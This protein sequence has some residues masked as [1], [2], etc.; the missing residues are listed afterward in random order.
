MKTMHAAIAAT[1]LA[2]TTFTA[3]AATIREN[4]LVLKI[5]G[6]TVTKAGF[7]PDE[8]SFDV[9]SGQPKGK[10][11]VVSSFTDSNRQLN[12]RVFAGRKGSGGVAT[13]FTNRTVKRVATRRGDASGKPGKLNFTFE[14][15]L[16]LNG[17]SFENFSFGQGHKGTNNN[18]WA[19]TASAATTSANDGSAFICFEGQSGTTYQI[20]MPGN[21]SAELEVSAITGAQSCGS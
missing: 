19:G 11:A 13:T 20:R 17:D 16:V 1:L 3:D 4:D 14:G 5:D 8:S 10:P 7:T 9:T 15:T 6:T 2:A 21:H 12:I 18:W